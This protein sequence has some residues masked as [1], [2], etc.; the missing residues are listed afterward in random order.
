MLSA[1]FRAARPTGEPVVQGVS[2][3]NGGYAV[4][5]LNSVVSGEPEQISQDQ[6][7]RTRQAMARRAASGET[8]ALAAQ[9]LES[10]DVVVAPDLFKADDTEAL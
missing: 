7:E 8:G 9:L 6:R 10:A 3:S 5:Q 4:F 1:V 2:L